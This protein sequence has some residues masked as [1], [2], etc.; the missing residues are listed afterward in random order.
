MPASCAGSSTRKR[1][2]IAAMYPAIGRW[3]TTIDCSAG[4]TSTT[5]P[6]TWYVR[7]IAGIVS[8]LMKPINVRTNL[9]MIH[10]TRSTLEPISLPCCM[11]NLR[12]H[13]RV[14]RKMI[15]GDRELRMPSCE[16]TTRTGKRFGLCSF[17]I[18]LYEV[19]LLNMQLAHELIDGC[20]RESGS[21][22][23]RSGG[24]DDKTVRCRVMRIDVHREYI[25]FIPNTFR[26]DDDSLCGNLVFEVPA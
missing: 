19:H 23:G 6:S 26:V 10:R 1:I 2:V 16:G 4:T 9:A 12:H 7:P 17:D 25:I 22:T 15:N 5:M 20:E 18:H 13:D 8:R 3:D 11:N 21:C 24:M 14:V